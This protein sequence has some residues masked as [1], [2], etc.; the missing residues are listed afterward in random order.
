M[1][2]MMPTMML[3]MNCITVLI[4]WIGGYSVNDGAMQVG[5]YDGIY[6]VY[7]ADY[8]GIPDDL[9]DLSH[10]SESSSI[11]NPCRRSIEER[12]ENQ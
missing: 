11:S 12:D 8:Y 6:P 3:I 9:Y 7:N 5:D 4:V 10:A 1:T 2:F